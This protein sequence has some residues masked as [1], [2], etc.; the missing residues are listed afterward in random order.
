MGL[1]EWLALGAFV[2]AFGK[3]LMDLYHWLRE[4]RAHQAVDLRAATTAVVERDSIAIK[5]AEGALV[6][7]DKMLKICTETEERLR[8]RVEL[9][10]QK[11][12]LLEQKNAELERENEEL[13][14]QLREVTFRLERLEQ[15]NG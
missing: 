5:G 8:V 4:R 2:L 15:S 14:K 11:N 3:G 1:T 13:Q 12:D 7:M 10:E 9:L 6:L